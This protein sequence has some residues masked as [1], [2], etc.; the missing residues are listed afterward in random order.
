MVQKIVVISTPRR[1][2]ETANLLFG[3][4]IDVGAAAAAAAAATVAVAV[5]ARK[6]FASEARAP[7]ARPPAS[8]VW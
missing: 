2:G 6:N 5:A 3:A 8:A 4:M 1:A 7:P